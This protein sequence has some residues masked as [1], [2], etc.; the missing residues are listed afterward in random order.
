M[1]LPDALHSIFHDSQRFTRRKWANSS[2]FISLHASQ[3][4][5]KGFP[6]DGKYYA[7]V[8]TDEDY[9]ADDWE[10]VE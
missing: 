8:I 3:L 4:C 10:V 6:D 2:I 1:T 7:W 5:I 9:F